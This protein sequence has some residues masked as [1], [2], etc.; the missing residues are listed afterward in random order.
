MFQ[1]QNSSHFHCLQVTSAQ[2]HKAKEADAKARAAAAEQD[3]AGKQ[4]TL[5]EDSYAALVDVSSFSQ[6]PPE[7]SSVKVF[8]YC[9]AATKQSNCRGQ[10]AH[11]HRGQ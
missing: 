10:K 7:A 3:A 6:K 4:R 2:L 9:S 11:C 8:S 1:L 5:T